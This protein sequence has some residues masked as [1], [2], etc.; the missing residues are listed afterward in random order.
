MGEVVDDG[1]LRESI[2]TEAHRIAEREFGVEA[3]VARLVK[4]FDTVI[5]ERNRR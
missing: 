4:V 2:V 3:A 5:A 1:E